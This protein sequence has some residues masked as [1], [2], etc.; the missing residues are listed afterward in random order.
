MKKILYVEDEIALREDIVEFLEEEGYA[1]TVAS[2]GQ[3]GLKALP[4]VRPDL[5]LSDCLMPEMTGVEMMRSIR[6]EYPA[7]ASVPITR[8]ITKSGRKLCRT[9]L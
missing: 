9:L 6:R 4:S 3:E 1:V 5:I 8:P 7:F 2:N